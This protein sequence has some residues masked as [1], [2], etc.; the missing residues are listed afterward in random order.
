[1]LFVLG[2]ER[3]AAQISN[4]VNDVGKDHD[5]VNSSPTTVTLGNLAVNKEDTLHDENDGLTPSKSTGNLNK[6]TSYANLFTGGPSRKAM[7]FRT[8]FT[9]RGNR[10][11]VVV[12]VES[13]RVISEQFANTAYGFFLGKHLYGGLGC[14]A[15]KWSM[16]Y[17]QQSTYSKKVD[18][19]CELIERRFRSTNARA[20]I[21]VRAD[22]ELKDNIVV[23][24]LKL[25]GEGF[26]TYE[27]PK[28]IDSDVVKNMKKPS[29]TPRG[30]P[31]GLKVGFK[32]AK[33]VYRQVSKKNNVNT[34]GNKK[35]DME[36]TIE[37]S[38]SNPF[39]LLNSIDN[40]IDLGTNGGT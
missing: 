18:S 29:K 26:Y 6:G 40:N 30:V 19:R 27:C 17:S 23:A 4:T 3:G 38:N 39:D 31:V 34:S 8:L 2:M 5:G 22:V 15:C 36:P 37:V 33:Q 13:I 1:G 35:K 9:L 7:N 20:L 28:N 25:V 16:V 14:D 11:D 21:K 32:P 24:M 10:A 12:P